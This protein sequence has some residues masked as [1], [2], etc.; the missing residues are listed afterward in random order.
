MEDKKAFHEGDPVFAKVRGFVPYPARILGRAEGVKKLKFSV[1]FYETNEKG[2]IG[3]EN[4]WP[5]TVRTA[6]KLVT[7]KILRKKHFEPALKEMCRWHSGV[8]KFFP[9]IDKLEETEELEILDHSVD[10]TPG[11]LEDPLQKLNRLP[12]CEDVDQE[13]TS[14][15]EVLEDDGEAHNSGDGDSGDG[16]VEEFSCNDCGL[17]LDS[18]G[19]LVSHAV[20]HFV[21]E[22]IACIEARK[23]EQLV[24]ENDATESF[25]STSNIPGTSGSSRK[26][27]GKRSKASVK[28]K[29]PVKKAMKSKKTMILRENE[30][31]INNAFADKIVVKEDGTFHCKNCPTFAT[32]VRLVARSHA[33]VCGKR[34]TRGRKS[35]K[36]SCDDCGEVVEGK[37]NLQKH[38]KKMHTMPT[39]Q[40]STCLKRLKSRV[41]YRRHLKTHDNN[42]TISCPHCPQ[43]FRFESY[44]NRHVYRVHIKSQVASIKN[45]IEAVDDIE[46]N[47]IRVRVD[48]AMEQNEI[49]V[50]E[51]PGEAIEIRTSKAR[52]QNGV[53]S[54]VQREAIEVFQEEVKCGNSYYWQYEASFPN[55]ER[56][57]SSSCQMFSSSLQVSCEEDWNAWLQISKAFNINVSVDGS[58]D[59]IVT[60]VIKEANGTERFICA[61]SEVPTNIEFVELI[62]AEVVAAAVAMSSDIAT[63]DVEE[64][65]VENGAGM[66]GKVEE[67]NHAG[68]EEKVTI[69]NILSMVELEC[70]G[71]VPLKSP[72]N[73]TR[74]SAEDGENNT[75][76]VDNANG[77]TTNVGYDV[78]VRAVY[79][80]DGTAHGD[81]VGEDTVHAGDGDGGPVLAIDD[82]GE[83]D[84]GRAGQSS[85]DCGL[86]SASGFR[87]RWFLRRHVNLMHA[88]SVKCNICGNI[89]KDKY[90]Y[91]QHSKN[92]YYW[93]SRAGCSF[94]ERRKSR[95][96]SHEKKHDREV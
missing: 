30:L 26:I 55:I 19:A 51:A 60:A 61:G 34:K 71:E 84:T 91:L 32:S 10:I 14:Y 33:N 41:T 94:H 85:I 81:D 62:V 54:E 95:V 68:N 17:I 47:E 7:P 72:S 65:M 92:C 49:V 42:L 87:N 53:D 63:D 29:G 48:N 67:E 22:K 35:K 4:L 5:V 77:D 3:I 8:T 46:Q 66:S 56:S 79:G 2:D 38:I 1:L 24:A 31:E 45:T 89:F 9:D 64:M 44:K 40:C 69:E 52:E 43:M 76:I 73:G 50:A 6:E 82:N 27:Q 18:K 59:A 74:Y 93:C 90:H 11:D 36:L 39:Y 96:E 15:E 58:N 12:L 37:K 23:V 13:N 70:V 80:V 25:P 86:C 20:D 21:S 28:A 83:E 88:E 16:I 57:N 75:A 78:T